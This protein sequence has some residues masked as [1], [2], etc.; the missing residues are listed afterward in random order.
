MLAE[1]AKL[2]GEGMWGKLKLRW[3]SVWASEASPSLLLF[4]PGY[5]GQLEL[6]SQHMA[7]A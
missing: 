6:G 1:G 7:S 2:L 3:S 4:S 5:A